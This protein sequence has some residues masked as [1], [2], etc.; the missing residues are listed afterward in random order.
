[1]GH[2][3]QATPPGGK[4]WG[5]VVQLLDERAGAAEVIA[6]SAVAAEKDLTAA[7][8]APILAAAIHLLAMIPQAARQDDFGG[9]L[10]R[11]GIDVPD[12]PMLGDLTVGVSAALEHR[13]S[14]FPRND[15]GEIVGRALIGT[16]SAQ[17][18]D[19]LPALF[20][21]GSDDVQRA[22][23]R[24]GQPGNFAHAARAFFARLLADTLGFWLDRTLSSEVG[25]GARIESLAARE[26]FDRAL[27]QYCVEATRIIHEFAGA[28]YGKTL[29]RQ[30]IIST[31]SAGAFAAVAMKKLG[32]ELRRKQLPGA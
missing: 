32:D 9:Q 26:S 25:I 20:E 10:R 8:E 7:A 24:L 29:Y 16:L 1:M 22:T 6:A 21:A 17:V 23:A 2:I 31:D 27:E 11:L 18:G 19:G 3:H 30:S 12:E 15:F 5:E 14:A 4:R 28:W 13:R